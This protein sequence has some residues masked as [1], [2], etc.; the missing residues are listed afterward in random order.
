[1]MKQFQSDFEFPLDNVDNVISLCPT[2]HRGIHLGVIEYKRFL[3]DTIYHRRRVMK[4]FDINDL[5]SFYNSLKQE[6][7]I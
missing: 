7:K 6:V 4:D 3:I 2:C 5:Y 1:M